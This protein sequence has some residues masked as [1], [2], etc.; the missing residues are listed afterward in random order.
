MF[1]PDSFCFD[2]ITRSGTVLLCPAA[3]SFVSFRHIDMSQ[4]C[5]L[6]CCF[7]HSKG[8]YNIVVLVI[9]AS[10][11]THAS[12]GPQP[13]PSSYPPTLQ[14]HSR[15]SGE[16]S[17]F[18]PLLSYIFY[19]LCSFSL[20]RSALI[21]VLVSYLSLSLTLTLSPPPPLSPPLHPLLLKTTNPISSSTQSRT[22][23]A[24]PSAAGVGPSTTLPT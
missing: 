3:R 20:L 1:F 5:T 14:T 23:S 15:A 17:W 2:F 10:H 4:C 22:P 6:G 19:M 12:R 9:I 11:S 21:V 8:T 7:T 24:L 13:L 16:G 18:G